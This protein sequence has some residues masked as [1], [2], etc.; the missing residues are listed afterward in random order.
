VASIVILYCNVLYH[1]IKHINIL[2]IWYNIIILWGNCRVWSTS[3]TET[4]LCG[5]Y[6]YILIN[7]YHDITAV[8]VSVYTTVNE[9]I[10]QHTAVHYNSWI[11]RT[12][13]NLR[14]HQTATQFNS[15]LL[16]AEYSLSPVAAV[17]VHLVVCWRCW[18]G[19][20]RIDVCGIGKV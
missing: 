15:I 8:P 4:S 6:L 14:L 16:E 7:T 3:L 9:P 20:G 12:A 17:C 10:Q 18:Q 5:A 2:Y 19:R 13:T 1:Y 11:R